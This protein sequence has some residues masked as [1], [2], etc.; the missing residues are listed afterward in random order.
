MTS[1]A[2]WA[3]TFGIGLT[4]I[5]PSFQLWRIS[6]IWVL[7]F[8]V[9]F[10]TAMCAGLTCASIACL[11]NSRAELL[12]FVVRRVG[13]GTF[14]TSWGGPLV[15]ASALLVRGT[16]GY[17]GIMAMRYIAVTYKEDKE[18]VTITFGVIGMTINFFGAIVSTALV[19]TGVI[20]D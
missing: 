14:E 19:E 12:G 1:L 9:L 16:D 3:Y 18:A 17:I 7:G 2:Q 15:V 8:S 13:D 20:A 4:I 10:L 11:L 6:L 5:A